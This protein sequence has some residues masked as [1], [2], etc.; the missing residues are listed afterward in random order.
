MLFILFLGFLSKSK[1]G[2]FW[3][4]VYL[5]GVNLLHFSVAFFRKA[6]VDMFEAVFVKQETFIG[7]LI[8]Y[9]REIIFF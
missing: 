5:A 8:I 6:P 3:G 2:C 4:V 7:R 1:L 9:T